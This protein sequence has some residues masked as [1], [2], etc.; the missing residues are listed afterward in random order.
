M[1]KAAYLSAKPKD[2]D[3]YWLQAMHSGEY[4]EGDSKTN[5]LYIMAANL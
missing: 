5:T 2:T 4:D 3:Y 1:L